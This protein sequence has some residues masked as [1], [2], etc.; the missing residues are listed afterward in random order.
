MNQQT[1]ETALSI[2]VEVPQ[3]I[4]KIG[5]LPNVKTSTLGGDLWWNNLAQCNGWRVQRNSL[6]GHCR[7]LDD[8]NV[9]HAWGS[10][11]DIMAFF[12]KVL[13]GR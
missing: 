8:Q 4:Q 2:L 3:L 6:T 13:D 12:Q 5:L 9:R 10:E 1:L 7:I 11:R